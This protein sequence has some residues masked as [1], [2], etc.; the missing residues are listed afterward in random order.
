[1]KI[2]VLGRIGDEDG[3]LGRILMAMGPVDRFVSVGG[4]LAGAGRSELELRVGR[5]SANGAIVL[6]GK[7]DP[8][9]P[10][11]YH[12][13]RLLLLGEASFFHAN[14]LR[15]GNGH[16]IRGVQDAA[17][18]FPSVP[19]RIGCYGNAPDRAAW[20]LGVD[21]AVAVAPSDGE[22]RLEPSWRYLLGLGE[23]PGGGWGVLDLGRGMF[24]FG[25]AVAADSGKEAKSC[26]TS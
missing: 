3:A 4:T 12:P 14:P 17:F 2:G 8:D 9:V 16:G 26:C 6:Q 5:L 18:Y 20:V 13:G 25:E 24:R 19:G 21:G 11:L 23:T 10:G 7:G 15:P 22:L 1:M